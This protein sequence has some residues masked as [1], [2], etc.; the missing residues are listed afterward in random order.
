MIIVFYYLPTLLIERCSV[1]IIT[2]YINV[3]IMKTRHSKYTVRHCQMSI[4][5][6]LLY[7]VLKKIYMTFTNWEITFERL[8]YGISYKIH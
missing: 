2:S 1:I 4:A 5:W 7:K 3:E 8:V 6:G